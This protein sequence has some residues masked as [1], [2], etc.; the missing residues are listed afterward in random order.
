[1]WLSHE[2][3]DKS[4][5]RA[6]QRGVITTQHQSIFIFFK[7]KN[8]LSASFSEL[9]ERHCEPAR[10]LSKSSTFFRHLVWKKFLFHSCEV[11][12]FHVLSK[13]PSASK[14]KWLY[15]KKKK[16][17]FHGWLTL[18]GN[19]AKLG[20]RECAYRFTALFFLFVCLFICLFVAI[21]FTGLGS[22]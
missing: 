5:W 14:L 10:L 11:C 15:W 17:S 3:G 22:Q 9:R 21:F 6:Q 13:A 12:Y 18:T 19:E 20:K 16:A 8:I 7:K 4:R 2:T 1:M